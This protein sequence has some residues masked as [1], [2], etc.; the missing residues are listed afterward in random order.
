[1]TTP[2]EQ[3]K[4]WEKDGKRMEIVCRAICRSRGINSR[5]K[6]AGTGFQK[7]TDFKKDAEYILEA[8]EELNDGK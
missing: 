5:A 2:I 8:L 1:M 4:E 3:Q 7:W 6:I